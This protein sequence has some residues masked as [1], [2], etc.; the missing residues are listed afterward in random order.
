MES[1]CSRRVHSGQGGRTR[2]QE[3]PT[4]SIAAGDGEGDFALKLEAEPGVAA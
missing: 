1:G 4:C 3:T 2:H